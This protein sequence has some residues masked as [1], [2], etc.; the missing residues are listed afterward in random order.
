MASTKTTWITA[1][2][3]ASGALAAFTKKHSSPEHLRWFWSL[4]CPSK[5]ESLRISNQVASLELAK[6]E[7]EASRR[8]WKRGPS[9]KRWP[10]LACP[11]A[12]YERCADFFEFS[13]LCGAFSA[14]SLL[15]LE[16][17]LQPQSVRECPA[18]CPRPISRGEMLLHSAPLVLTSSSDGCGV[19]AS[20][21]KIGNSGTIVAHRFA[22][23][24][25]SAATAAELVGLP[26]SWIERLERHLAE[27]GSLA[28]GNFHEDFFVKGTC[29]DYR[30]TP[31]IGGH[32]GCRARSARYSRQPPRRGL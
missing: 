7:F 15:P 20:R 32:D 6:P 26:P 23:G 21:R 27:Y 3:A 2:S 31:A 10:F 19:P 29:D 24:G 4:F 16:C 8:Q 30:H 17:H 25:V 5:P 14:R 9:W 22:H 12:A 11:L 13:S 28:V 1:C 18:S